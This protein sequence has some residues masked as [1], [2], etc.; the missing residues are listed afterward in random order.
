MFYWDNSSVFFLKFG[1][2]IVTFYSNVTFLVIIIYCLKR[3]F[4]DMPQSPVRNE[5]VFLLKF[6]PEFCK[7][8]LKIW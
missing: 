4:D 3:L 5:N 1:I 8:K 6:S 7:S 2:W